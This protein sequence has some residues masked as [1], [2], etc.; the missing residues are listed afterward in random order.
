[1]AKN[2][3]NS[4]LSY[5]T[6]LRGKDMGPKGLYAAEWAMVIYALFT[7][8]LILFT[9]TNLHNPDALIWGRVHTALITVALWVVYLIWPCR[10]MEL[11]RVVILMITL[12][13]WYPDTYELNRQFANLDHIFANW[14]QALFG[15]QPALTMAETFSSKVVSEFMCMGYSMYYPMFGFLIFYTFFKIH[16]EFQRVAFT[17]AAGFFM[18]YVIFVLFPVTGPQYY[19]AAV[20]VNDIAAGVF[21]DVGYYFRD[22]QECLPIPGWKDGLFHHLVQ[23]AHESGERP[24][25]AFPS[26]HV[27]ISTITMLLIISLRK[28][29]LLIIFAIPYLCLCFSTVYIQAHYA[30]DAIAGFITAIPAYFLL[31]WIYKK[32]WK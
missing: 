13:W 25:A 3:K 21:P 17:L 11:A 5:L 23:T 27:S 16:H 15:F 10:I 19:Y 32:V 7:I 20:G 9:S 30:I 18:Y 26:S 14:E 4:I 2:K 8:V 24:T 12:S 22:C 1:M 6:P 28:W 31:Q 29:R